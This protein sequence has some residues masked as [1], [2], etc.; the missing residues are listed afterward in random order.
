[1]TKREPDDRPTMKTV[2]ARYAAIIGSLSS[3]TLRS[4]VRKRTEFPV[5]TAFM[6]IGHLF[7]T[8][9][10]TISLKPSVPTPSTPAKPPAHP[11][12]TAASTVRSSRIKLPTL[13]RPKTEASE[14]APAS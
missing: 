4:R 3:S 1:M 10:Y 9:R 12:A 11:A 2:V 6:G 14:T 13:R 5:V 8:A 7:T